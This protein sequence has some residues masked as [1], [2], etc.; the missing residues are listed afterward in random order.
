MEDAVNAAW[1]QLF[2]QHDNDAMNVLFSPA[3]NEA[4]DPIPLLDLGV[5]NPLPVDL[6]PGVLLRNGPNPQPGPKHAR[7]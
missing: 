1:Q 5:K 2:A 6:P 4:P 7:M 3:A